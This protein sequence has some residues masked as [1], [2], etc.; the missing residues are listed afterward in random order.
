MEEVGVVDT[1]WEYEK[2]E[3]TKTIEGYR[4][5]N[6]RV[7]EGLPLGDDFTS[8]SW[9]FCNFRA[10]HSYSGV[11]WRLGFSLHTKLLGFIQ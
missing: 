11:P 2:E 4:H 9:R 10:T 5:T 8:T 3:T 6:R 7:L 1:L